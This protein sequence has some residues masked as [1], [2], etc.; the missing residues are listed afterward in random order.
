[1]RRY[2][3]CRDVVIRINGAAL[4][5]QNDEW[6]E[7]CRYM[8]TGILAASGQQSAPQKPLGNR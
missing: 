1:M 6:T 7:G 2:L 8:G 5:G 4:A 3:P